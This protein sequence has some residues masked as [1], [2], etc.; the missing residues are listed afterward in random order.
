[1]IY[2]GMI[3]EGLAVT[4]AVH[5][6]YNPSKH[7]PWNE[8]E[9]G[10]HYA[11]ALAS[12]GILTA[13]EDYYYDGPKGVLG[14]SP[15]ITPEDFVGFFTAAEGWGNLK[16]QITADAQMNSINVAWGDVR[17]SKLVV[18]AAKVKG[19]VVVKVDGETVQSTVKYDNG[20]ANISFAPQNLTANQVIE[21]VQE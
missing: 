13:L 19:D 16:Q 8:I 21:V 2:E 1:M 11:R 12:W 3:D 4:R 9:C 20:M 15:R 7:N 18:P 14:F 5:D 6:R 10:D 17:L